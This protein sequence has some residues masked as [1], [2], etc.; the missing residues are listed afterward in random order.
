MTFLMSAA[1]SQAA[2]RTIDQTCREFQTGTTSRL[3]VF[4]SGTCDAFVCS[5]RMSDGPV[6]AHRQ[7]APGRGRL[8][9][10]AGWLHI[11]RP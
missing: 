2:I 3:N 11:W 8:A 1:T 6:P 10:E 5:T 4:S 9:G 7:H